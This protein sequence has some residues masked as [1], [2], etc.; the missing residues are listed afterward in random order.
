MTDDYLELID[1]DDEPSTLYIHG[2][3][4]LIAVCHDCN[5]AV[6]Y[7]GRW[8]ISHEFHGKP[9]ATIIPADQ[10][11]HFTIVSREAAN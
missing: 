11:T 1:Y 10:V 2:K 4:G 6:R 3:N 7:K 5:G 8:T 9:A